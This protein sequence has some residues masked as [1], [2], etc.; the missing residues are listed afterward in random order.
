MNI[1]RREYIKMCLA[2]VASYSSRDILA[3]ESLSTTENDKVGNFQYI[4]SNKKL[5]DTFLD[6][7]T[8]VFHLYPE[9]DLHELIKELSEKYKNDQD[10]YKALQASINQ[11]KPFLSDFTYAL[12]ALAKQ[13]KIMTRQTLQL[14]DQNKRYEGYM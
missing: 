12:P 9:N 8:N 14:L 1:R 5:R 3:I 10:I 7:Y 2:L 4:Y 13:K 6:F 11:I